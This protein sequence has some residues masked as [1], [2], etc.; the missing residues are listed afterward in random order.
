M[1]LANVLGR[2]LVID[3][4]PTSPNSYVSVSHTIGIMQSMATA[5]A[6]SPIIQQAVDEAT[7]ELPSTASD[8]EIISALFYYVKSKVSFTLDETFLQDNLSIYSDSELLI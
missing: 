3:N 2:S 6:R 1:P 7:W 5:S 8:L 4:I